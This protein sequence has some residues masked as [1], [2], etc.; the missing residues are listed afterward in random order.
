MIA[1]AGD[2]CYVICLKFVSRARVNAERYAKAGRRRRSHTGFGDRLILNARTRLRSE[3]LGSSL[4]VKINK[5]TSRLRDVECPQCNARFL[6]RRA[7]QA[8][9]DS[10]G[11]ESYE[12]DCKFCG[13]SLAGVIDPL[14]GE[15]ILSVVEQEGE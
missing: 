7:R 12:L 15:L 2:R 4:L 5:E 9:F 13:V 1:L 10:H 3:S 8:R 6:F 11:F 14:E